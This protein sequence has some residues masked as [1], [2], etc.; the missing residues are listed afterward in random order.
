MIDLA[1]EQALTLKA[2][3]KLPEMQR[4][5]R[6]LHIATIYR[7]ATRGC[8]G[9]VLE[10]VIQGSARVT[11]REAID[12]FFSRLSGEL[13]SPE[14]EPQTRTPSRRQRDSARAE[15]SLAAAG[16]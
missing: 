9:Q 13:D 15:K 5:G 11:T 7:W 1:A 12:R 10:T 14:A 2:A 3:T 4:D 16:W 8:R 6:R